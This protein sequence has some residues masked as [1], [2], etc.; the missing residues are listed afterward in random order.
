ML[1]LGGGILEI[2]LLRLKNGLIDHIDIDEILSFDAETLKDT[3]ILQLEKVHVKGFIT[4]SRDDSYDLSLL[5]EGVMVLPCSLTLKP[6]PYS[7]SISIEDNLLTLLGEIDENVKKIENSIDI[8]PIIWENILMEIPI[9]VVN[10]D[11]SSMKMEG[12]GWKFI[13]EDDKKEVMNSEFAK[14]KDLF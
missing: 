14:L 5:V 7:F 9:R 11:T 3:T 2:D 12:E 4:R 13:T 10:E 8:L 6:T 1:I